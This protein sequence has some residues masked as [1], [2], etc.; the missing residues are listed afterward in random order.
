M[1]RITG[2][3]AKGLME[4]YQAVYAP[5]EL[6]EEQVWEEVENWVNS[7]LEEGYDLSE[8]TWD[9][10]YEAYSQLDEYAI[11]LIQAGLRAALPAIGR[12]ALP[13]IGAATKL[14]QGRG[15]S[16]P[17]EPVDYG[18]MSPGSFASSKES[19]KRGKEASELNRKQNQPT[20]PASTPVSGRTIRG[21]R[22]RIRVA[23][24][25][26]QGSTTSTPGASAQQTKPPEKPETPKPELT[27]KDLGGEIT[28]QSTTSG[29]SSA[30]SSGGG[31]AGKPTID[32][33]KTVKDLAKK[34]PEALNQTLGKPARERFFGTT[35]AGQVTRGATVAGVSALDIGGKVADPS[36][37]SALSAVGSVGPGAAGT[38]LQGAGNIPG[39]KGT[40]LGTGARGTGTTLRQVGREMRDQ[41]K[42]TTSTPSQP[43][44]RRLLPGLEK[45]SYDLPIENIIT[46]GPDWNSAPKPKGVAALT[47]GSETKVFIPGQ[48][49]QF[50]KTARRWAR[51][52]GY[53]NWN[54]IPNPS[55]PAKP[56]KPAPDQGQGSRRSGE[57][58]KDFA[59]RQS[60]EL[61]KDYPTTSTQTQTPAATT[62]PPAATTQ[63]QR[64]P[65]QPAPATSV[66]TQSPT[67]TQPP[68]APPKVSP[69]KPAQTGDRTK[70]LTTW[71]TTP[72]NRNMINTV[73][74]PQQKAILSAA[75]KGT[76]MPA[77]RPISKDI[78]DIKK[79]QTASRA[80][81]GVKEAYDLVLE[82]LL[83]Q[84]H[85]ET[86]EEAN[87]VMMVM[88]AE[89][90]G[91]IVEGVMPEPIDPTA[92]NK[93]Q[94]FATQQGKIRALESG[95][96]TSGEKSAA[97]SKLKGPQLPGV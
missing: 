54:K 70:D 49:W 35:T 21:E 56:A 1:S 80:R 13:A 51:A 72:R 32:P 52:Q 15:Q 38:V 85:V 48:G 93:S 8:Y 31:G 87:Y 86:V 20:Q 81:Q 53:T 83:S 4:A 23:A 76:A 18:Q 69:S 42:T 62:Q 50:P 3:D 61:Q 88:D 95:A 19:E 84:R 30:S 40:S 55:Q 77:P 47:L 25:R 67:Q 14:L 22:P 64:L 16:K 59:A 71:A 79:M 37:P 91:S 43:E 65:V 60:A 90:I 7:L 74:T 58:N 96:A 78:E 24:T 68:A 73:G 63:P 2:S 41:T 33:L 57:S 11:P 27:A 75:D 28:R 36:K 5:Q 82:Y 89:T 17:Q 44:R 29:Q 10:M 26:P 39:I 94:R 6:T 34:A 9:E 97:Q 92:H 46:E 45:N 66:P 12:A